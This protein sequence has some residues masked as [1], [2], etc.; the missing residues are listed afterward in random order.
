MDAIWEPL[1]NIIV[2]Q[3]SS[4]Q[5][6]KIRN[7]YSKVPVGLH[8]MFMT[9][10]YERANIRA[11]E[12]CTVPTMIMFGEYDPLASPDFIAYIKSK[13]PET[14]LLLIPD[15]SNCVQMD[16]PAIVAEWILGFINK[17]IQSTPLMASKDFIYS[18]LEPTN[19]LDEWNIEINC[20]TSFSVK[21]HG[22]DVKDGWNQRQAKSIITYLAIN[23]SAS[24]DEL[25]EVFWPNVDIKKAKNN[26]RVSLS[27]LRG[28]VN[29]KEELLVADRDR[30]YLKGKIRCDAHILLKDLEELQLMDDQERAE[31]IENIFINPPSYGFTGFYH[32]YFLKLS[33]N[34]EHKLVGLAQWATRYYNSTGDYKKA[35]QFL[36]LVETALPEWEYEE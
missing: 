32:D 26:L 35:T 30:V 27:Y 25:C 2:H 9:M 1:S 7:M 15:A 11:I 21:I 28:I 31:K 12:Q 5:V 36:N 19:T 3:P 34:I 33:R 14:R 6:Q 16:Q 24:R 18:Y 10:V 22:D 29:T 20:L 23:T 17:P 4:T 13:L 8:E